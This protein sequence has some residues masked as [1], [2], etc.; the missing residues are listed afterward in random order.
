MKNAENGED[1]LASLL[2]AC[3]EALASGTEPACPADTPAEM[4]DLWQRGLAGMR[5]LRRNLTA[6]RPDAVSPE[7]T[8]REPL[9]RLGRFE[10][11]RELGR[12]GF[13]IVYLARDPLLARDV[14]LKVPRPECLI[15]TGLR[16]RFVRE[17]RAAA[18]LDD[19]HIVPLYE[20]GE[21]GPV[22]YL[23][24]AY[25]PGTNLAAWLRDSSGAVAP[26]EAAG[27]LATLADAIHYAHGRGVVHRD[28][29]PA[30]V[31]L[32]MADLGLPMADAKP[33]ISNL[34]SAIP[35]ITDFGIAK[36]LT[37][38]TSD[39]TTGVV[40][41]TPAYMAPEQARGSGEVGPAADVY[42]LGAILYEML[43]GRPPFRG[44]TPLETL[45][46]VRGAEPAAPRLLQPN[47]P[48]D[49]ETIALKCL[50]KGQTRRYASAAE[51]AADL[52][53]FLNGEPVRA[54]PPSAWYRF[55]KYARRHKSGLATAG[56]LLLLL[57][58]LSGGL[59]WVVRDRATRQVIQELEVTRALKGARDFCRC[60]R[61]PEALEAVKRA[62][63]LLAGGGGGAQLRR[64]VDRVRLDVAMAARLEGIRLERATVKDG[65]FDNAAADQ[66]YGDAFQTYGLDVT[67]LDVDQAVEQIQES[68]ITDHLVAALDDWLL[69]KSSAAAPGGKRLL[70]VLE[71]ADADSWRNE[72]RTAFASRDQKVLKNLVRDQR[73][74]L[75]PPTTVV[76]LGEALPQA[77]ETPLAIA[78]LRTAQRQYPNDFWINH[79]LALCLIRSQ[80]VQAAEAVGYYRA[81]LAVRPDSLGVLTNLGNALQARGDTAGAIAV[82]ERA[83]E[84]K[85]ELAE[86][87]NNLG[88]SLYA[89]GDKPGAIAAYHKAI[90]LEPKLSTAHFNLGSA[91]R[92]M[93]DLPGA[94][95]AYQEAIALQPDY[96]EAH[97]NL[98]YALRDQ[99]DLAG[100][101]AAYHRAI[102]LKPEYAEAHNN[103]GIALH[104]K[105]DLP[106]AV[107]AYQKAVAF[108]PDL[109]EA[110]SNL[111]IAL[112]VK[113]DLPGA[114]AAYQKAIALKPNLAEGHNNLGLVLRK[115]GDTP[116]A[117][118][119]F[120]KAVALDP[121][122]AQAHWNLGN[123]LRENGDLPRAIAAFQRAVDLKP[124]MVE[125]LGNLGI[126]LREN[127]DLAGACAAF[128]RIIALKPDHAQ[129]H[130]SLANALRQRGEFRKALAEYCR[131][132]ELGS[133][134]PRWPYPSAQSLR[135]CERLVELDE[136]LPAFRDGTTTPASADERIELAELCSLK[137][138]YRA[139][140]R[141][142]EEAFA[143]QPRLLAAQRYNA[144][145]AAAQ[146]GCGQGDDVA[147]LEESERA[148]LRSL[149]LAWLR[150]EL[151]QSVNQLARK[152]QELQQHLQ[153]WQRDADLA[154]V[155]ESGRLAQ[156]PLA[157]QEAWRR[158][159]AEVTTTLENNRRAK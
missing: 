3:D 30:N 23:A 121:K 98:G 147:A 34:Q 148:R 31:L 51:L 62:D 126:A 133:K 44:A 46:L 117:I 129:A 52:R 109:A 39:T 139:A 101:I 96:P 72:F 56:L 140:T 114:I 68:A 79:T 100:A 80:P 102:A 67:G 94:V 60:D 78:L 120:H 7:A 141:F 49:L 40:L 57:T 134:V 143:A 8:T 22:C 42:A 53:R 27:L 159:W 43:T 58:L 106:G 155:R 37:A 144:A 92:D 11:V 152:P 90:A 71:R 61:L 26:R 14:A 128:E 130:Y 138:L 81:A 97:N 6:A 156:L 142:N 36:V 145:C 35:K 112:Y 76:L 29:K 87:H 41:G 48:R 135:E 55:R 137:R 116:G 50:E 16:E 45:D 86:A 150:D 85:P 88:V 122:Y 154:G 2:V 119:A 151:T 66:D 84:L 127:G 95:A 89:K 158:L 5:L 115:K 103:L 20:A 83:I 82:Y 113:G 64:S 131:G 18:G 32:Q 12:G 153:H 15:D 59:G 149:A 28:L 146:A 65:Q 33:A 136:K 73:V 19:P 1:D 10:L 99:G 70:A 69:A 25:C 107:A 108:N 105:G 124:E 54:C 24:A 111:G 47:L 38:E 93:G 9:H 104:V 125:A 118:G 123:A 110:H 63:A 77:G 13:G 75:Q 17:A 91:L 21:V 4:H 132:H 74:W 157:E